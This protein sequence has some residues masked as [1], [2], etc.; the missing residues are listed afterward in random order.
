M[1]TMKFS[2]AVLDQE[3][4]LALQARIHKF[5]A[6]VNLSADGNTLAAVGDAQGAGIPSNHDLVI[7][8]LPSK[9][10]VHTWP[11]PSTPGGGNVSPFDLIALSSDGTVLAQA[12]ADGF[13]HEV[14]SPDGTTVIWTDNGV[15]GPVCLAPTAGN[16]LAA[17]NGFPSSMGLPGGIDIINNGSLATAIDGYPVGWLDATHLLVGTYESGHLNTSFAGAVIVSNTGTKVADSPLPEIKT[18]QLLGPDSIYARELNEIVS[19]TT[20][21]VSWMSGD[22]SS[23]LG[24]VAGSHVVFVSG[25]RVLALSQ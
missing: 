16:P 8:S 12:G 20:G 18:L 24:A 13:G 22:A 3:H 2:Q 6:E 14:T 5:S 11:H 9:N 1:I 4:T 7:Y 17:S 25:A 15:P 21:A 10:V 19:P 23:Q